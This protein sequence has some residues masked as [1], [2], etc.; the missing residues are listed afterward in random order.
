MLVLVYP[1]QNK[2]NKKEA[3]EG[4]KIACMQSTRNNAF[5]S[6]LLFVLKS[7]LQTTILLYSTRQNS[8]NRV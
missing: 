3:R 7:F 6:F 8:V 5:K 1:F 2:N 4:A